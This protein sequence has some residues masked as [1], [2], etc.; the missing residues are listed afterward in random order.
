MIT[1]HKLFKKAFGK[2]QSTTIFS[3]N[4]NQTLFY[5]IK[6]FF[7]VFSIKNCSKINNSSIFHVVSN[8]FYGLKKKFV[9]FTLKNCSSTLISKS[10]VY[11]CY[12]RMIKK[13]KVVALH[14][15]EK[16]MN[17]YVLQLK[18]HYSFTIRQSYLIVNYFFV[19]FSQIFC[20][21]KSFFGVKQNV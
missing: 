11:S 15:E 14:E 4:R 2:K 5:V 16:S 3:C 21:K 12:I 8:P 7:V 17:V 20:S 9:V 10:R 6:K 13:C 1:I 19:V 18:K